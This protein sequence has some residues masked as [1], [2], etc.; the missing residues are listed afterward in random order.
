MRV[1][2]MQPYFFP[3]V[4]FF[5]LI[6]AVDKFVIYD[7]VNYIKGGWINRNYFLSPNGKI[8]CTMRVAKASSFTLINSMQIIDDF[9]KLSRTIEFAY[10]KAPYYAKVYPLLKEVFTGNK[11]NLALFNANA[12]QLVSSYIGLDAEF[13]I[14]SECLKDKNSVGQEKVISLC[15]SIGGSQY[16]NPIGGQNLYHHDD[17]ARNGIKL[18]FLE[19]R[20]KSYYQMK[21]HFTPNLSIIDV[22]MYNSV[23]EI[24]KLLTE[25]KL[26]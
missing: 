26:F 12:L 4:G 7:D 13:L 21:P 23:D 6:H 11:K 9:I 15:K 20:A 19:S 25:Y 17:F 18:S 24:R 14:S 5:Q 1:A 10:S 22:L 2:I 8:L 16:V 3:Y